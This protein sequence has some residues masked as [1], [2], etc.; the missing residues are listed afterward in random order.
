[1]KQIQEQSPVLHELENKGA[2]KIIGCIYDIR[3]ARITLL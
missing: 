1:V 2:I 3:T